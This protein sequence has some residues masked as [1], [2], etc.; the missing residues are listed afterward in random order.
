MQP[1]QLYS[2]NDPVLWVKLAIGLLISV[3]SL[4]ICIASTVFIF[5]SFDKLLSKNA[6]AAVYR[7]QV[8]H[9]LFDG[10]PS[11]RLNIFN[12]CISKL[13]FQ[14]KKKKSSLGLELH[15]QQMHKTKLFFKKTI[16]LLANKYIIYRSYSTGAVQYMIMS[17]RRKCKFNILTKYT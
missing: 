1:F 14:K 13:D 7:G 11:K 16:E 9:N 12:I 10:R 3:F 6:N 4:F 17:F 5:I 2:L 15:K 8:P